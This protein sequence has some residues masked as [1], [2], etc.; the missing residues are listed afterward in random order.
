MVLGHCVAQSGIDTPHVPA[1]LH[2]ALLG[3]AHPLA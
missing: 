1:A 2:D 3:T